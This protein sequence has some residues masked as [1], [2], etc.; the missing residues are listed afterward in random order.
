MERVAFGKTGLEVTRLG[1]GLAEFL[2]HEVGA[3]VDEARRVLN[4]ALDGGI[5]F[6]DTAACYGNTEELIGA[7]VSHRRSEYVLATKAGH[8]VED[9]PG[10]AWT[11]L[12]IEHS[13]DRSLKRLKTDYVDIVQLH[14]C[15]LD[16]LARGE[17]IEALVKAKDAGKMRFMGFSGDNEAA[18]WAVDSGMFATLQTSLNLVEQGAYPDLLRA[19]E[20]QGA[21]VIVKRPVANGAWGKSSSPYQYADEYFRRAQLFAEEG[22]IPGE[23]DDPILFAMGFVFAHPEVHTAIIGTHNPSHVLSN[24]ELMDRLPISQ[25]AVDELHRRF[26]RLG[27]DWRQLT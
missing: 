11:A 17:V 27:K 16:V 5:N 19:A 12:T 22:P 4:N 10:G 3:G 23:P 14:S 20:A 9:A 21:G 2:R 13:I 25:E 26:E 7:T 8:A 18:R 24:I 6:L 15:G 1:L